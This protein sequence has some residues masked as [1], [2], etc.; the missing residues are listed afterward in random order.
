FRVTK[1][2]FINKV[3]LIYARKDT[4]LYKIVSAKDSSAN[5]KNIQVNGEYEFML[6]SL[7]PRQFL[8]K[9]DLSPT[10]LPNVDGVIFNDTGITLEKDSVNDLFVAENIKGLCF[11]QK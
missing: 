3:Y 9:Y 11:S 2:D 6:H 1:I 10:A 5:C 4:S 8:G 7:F